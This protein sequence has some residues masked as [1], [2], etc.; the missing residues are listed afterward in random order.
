M[1]INVSLMLDLN[2]ETNFLFLKHSKRLF[3]NS[4]SLKID[5]YILEN[6]YDSFINHDDFSK[7]EPYFDSIHKCLN[8]NDFMEK[9]RIR[10]IQNRYRYMFIASK[11]VVYPEFVINKLIES[12]KLVVSPLIYDGNSFGIKQA[13]YIANVSE[14]AL[15]DVDET[16]FINSKINECSLSRIE[17]TLFDFNI[18]NK[19]TFNQNTFEEYKDLDS[20]EILFSELYRN[21]LKWNIN[22]SII[23]NKYE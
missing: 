6:E 11:S 12:K 20:S 1:F 14:T 3:S 23:A 9:S 13:E 10:C 4:E 7:I 17:G 22:T 2:M 18:L 21:N 15:V 16:T 8:E 5:V 19:I